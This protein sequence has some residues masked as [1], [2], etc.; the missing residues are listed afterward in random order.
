MTRLRFLLPT[1]LLVL[2][3]CVMTTGTAFAAPA[4]RVLFHN[5]GHGDILRDT[6]SLF[7]DSQCD[8][9]YGLPVKGNATIIEGP[10]TFPVTNATN[11][12]GNQTVGNVHYDGNGNPTNGT[13]YFIV[14]ASCGSCTAEVSARNG[15]T[16]GSVVTKDVAESLSLDVFCVAPSL[17]TSETVN[18]V[19]SSVST[20]QFCTVPGSNL[21]CSPVTSVAGCIP[22][23]FVFN[24]LKASSITT[25]AD[26][27]CG[28]HVGGIRASVQASSTVDFNDLFVLSGGFSRHFSPSSEVNQTIP[29]STQFIPGIGLLAAEL[30]FNEQRSFVD[31]GYGAIST[32]AAHLIVTNAQGTVYLD[33]HINDGSA[34]IHCGHHLPASDPMPTI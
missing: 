33:E 18:G 31:G 1:L 4:S 34:A 12:G 24:I 25:S 8:T 9:G 3:V 29:L 16:L 21:T 20:P 32:T 19:T 17:V 10:C 5:W 28:A 30:T 11:F 23:G 14:R 26:A 27:A 22:N 2:A 13:P 6:S 15:K 7:T